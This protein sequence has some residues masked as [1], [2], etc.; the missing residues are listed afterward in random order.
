MFTPISQLILHI[1]Q[2]SIHIHKLIP[3]LKTHIPKHRKRPLESHK[4]EPCR[5][6]YKQTHHISL[7]HFCLFLGYIQ[8]LKLQILHKH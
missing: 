7:H 4:Q 2:P 6:L 3:I 5:F 1:Q 8:S